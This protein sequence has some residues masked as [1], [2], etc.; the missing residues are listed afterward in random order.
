MPY[1]A[2]FTSDASGRM[3]TRDG[4]N[5][6]RA[7]SATEESRHRKMCWPPQPFEPYEDDHDRTLTARS[8]ENTLQLEGSEANPRSPRSNHAVDG[9][10]RPLQRSKPSLPLQRIA[11][12]YLRYLNRCVLTDHL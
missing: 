7:R 5:R 4:Q 11:Y 2:S 3:T 10:F 9:S 8:V 12:G 6:Q 1:L